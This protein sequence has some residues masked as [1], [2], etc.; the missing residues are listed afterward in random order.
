MRGGALAAVHGGLIV[1]CQAVPGDP[2]DNAGA[3]A[4][5]AR[6][7]AIG[8]AVGLRVNGPDNVAACRAVV[9]LPILGIH[10]L[11]DP[12]GRTIITPSLRAA[13]SVVEHGASMVAVEV[14]QRDRPNG[15]SAAQLVGEIR[16][17]LH[18]PVLGD[19]GSLEEG[20]EAARCCDAVITTF[21]PPPGNSAETAERGIGK[22]GESWAPVDLGLIANLRA[23]ISVPVI[24]EGR[25]WD[26]SDVRAAFEAGAHAVVIGTAITRPHYITARFVA[27]TPS[28]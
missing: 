23:A 27:A 5:F 4:E 19:I 25:F 18:V 20:V 2:F 1:S 17:K 8:G 16:A 15:V 14:R 10:K 28:R 6:A 13:E 9:S 12:A 3:I 24:A 21:A 26:P 11:P 22:F 7:A